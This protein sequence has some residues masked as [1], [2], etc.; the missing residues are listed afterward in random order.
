MFPTGN[1]HGGCRRRGGAA[2][3]RMA[4]GFFEKSL[5]AKITAILLIFIVA[6][7]GASIVISDALV[8]RIVRNDVE[9][10]TRDAARLTGTLVEVGL[11]RRATRVGLLA[12]LPV[13]RDPGAS[14][15]SRA[16][17]ITL[18]S[19]NWPIGEGVLLTDTNGNVLAGTGE[20]SKASS[21]AGTTWFG[22]ALSGGTAFTYVGDTAELAATRLDSPVLAVSAPLRDASDQI[23]GYAVAFT[24]IR[25]ISRAVAAVMI[26]TTGHGFLAS[27]SGGVIAGHLFP[28]SV[29][30]SGADRRRRENLLS[31]IALGNSGQTT[32]AYGGKSYLVTWVPVE[33]GQAAGPGL[34]W[35]VGV[36]SPTA[37]AYRSANQVALALLVPAVLLIAL[38]VVAAFKLGRG[39]TRPI[40][41]LVVS[42]EGIGSG[43]LTCDVP[44]RTR[45]QVGKLAAV[46]LRLRDNMRGALAE[47]SR[48]ADRMSVLAGEQSAGT[49]DVFRSTEEI[50]DS[51][52]VLARNMD[53]L[54]R[55]LATVTERCESAGGG[56]EGPTGHPEV[57]ELLRDCEILAAVSSSKAVEIAT[58]VQDQRAAARDVSAAARRLSD[59]ARELNSLVQQFKV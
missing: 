2:L 31:G 57:R 18:F 34:D 20:L 48:A 4:L 45:D 49:E 43:D 10:S 12:S 26:E 11:E 14:T 5:R 55:K 44:I 16:A 1:D 7:V 3:E 56:A 30:P 39:I 33:T 32:T 13:M 42:A 23:F 24:N 53:S 38:G 46:L 50:V 41:E 40:D 58:A 28:R 36:A 27:G 15:E 35:T 52:V 9:Q 47:A 51:V 29:E 59:T 37:E 6:A 8:T 54:T 25:D 19:E 21:A 22:N 17:T